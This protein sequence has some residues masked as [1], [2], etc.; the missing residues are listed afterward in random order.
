MTF[1]LV[2][3]NAAIINFCTGKQSQDDT[4]NDKGPPKLYILNRL[5]FSN[6]YLALLEK[7][8]ISFYI[9]KKFIIK[10]V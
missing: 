5:S 8:H 7:C 4:S 1:L 2:R 9:N 6:G 3:D 10:T